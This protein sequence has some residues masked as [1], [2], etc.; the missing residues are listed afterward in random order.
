MFQQLSTRPDEPVLPLAIACA[1]IQPLWSLYAKNNTYKL[2]NLYLI[3]ILEGTNQRKL[4]QVF[5][6]ALLYSQDVGQIGV[7]KVTEQIAEQFTEVVL[8]GI[9]WKGRHLQVRVIY[10]IGDNL[11]Q[12][13]LSGI[14]RSWS[15]GKSCRFCHFVMADLANANSADYLSSG[16]NQT[17]QEYMEVIAAKSNNDILPHSITNV[18]ALHRIPYFLMKTT[19]FSIITTFN[20]IMEIQCKMSKKTQLFCLNFQKPLWASSSE[21]ERKIERERENLKGKRDN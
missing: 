4:E 19:T 2:Y 15:H 13:Q 14:T 11:S 7:E 5:P 3:V 17:S 18:R 8:N 6:L 20:C 1:E 12:N 21:A 10:V 16:A 9:I